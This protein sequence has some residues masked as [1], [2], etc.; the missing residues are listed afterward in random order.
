MM[1]NKQKTLQEINTLWKAKC[2][3][4]LKEMATQSVPGEGN[5]DAD[6]MFIG[7]APGKKEDEQGMPF[8]GASGKFL[9]EMLATINLK[10][11]DIYITNIVKYRPPNNRDP[12]KEEKAQ[13]WPYLIRQLNIIQ[14]ELVVT[15]GRHS[16]LCFEPSLVISRDH[17]K[18]WHKEYDD[19]RFDLATLYHPAAALYNSK[20][21][22]VLFKDFASAVSAHISK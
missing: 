18:I 22:Q 8:I 16:G 9:S 12:S 10:R 6:I 14:P 2:T 20:L 5:P 21:R 1:R 4:V 13:F 11:E 15:L 19:L 7:E 17:G 3:C